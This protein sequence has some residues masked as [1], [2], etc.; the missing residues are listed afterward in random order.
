MS[1]DDIPPRPSA[2]EPGDDSEQGPGRRGPAPDG[3]PYNPPPP[4]APGLAEL[5]VRLARAERAHRALEGTVSELGPDLTRHL[6]GELETAIAEVQR[7]AGH[8][9][10]DRFRDVENVLGEHDAVLQRILART[11]TTRNPPVPWPALNAADAAEH[12]ARLADWID[13]IFVPWGEVTRDALPDCWALHRPVVV[14]LSW[15]RSAY[16]QAYLPASDPSVAADWHV[17]WSPAVIDKIKI[18]IDSKWCR[19]GE[20]M[21]TVEDSNA[22]RRAA[23]AGARDNPGQPAGGRAELG[24]MQLASREVW[25]AFFIQARDQDLAWRRARELDQ[26]PAPDPQSPP[27]DTDS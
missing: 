16:I 25:D 13:E 12:W 1:S 15:L 20:H 8:D 2:A 26:Q 18:L 23:Q 11:E 3:G 6:R 7:T 17:R 10:D 9:V 22:R 24:R 19:P 21:I 4:P 14:Q 5:Q 27:P